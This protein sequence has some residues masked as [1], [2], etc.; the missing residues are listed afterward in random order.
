MLHD[1]HKKKYHEHIRIQ[2][3]NHPVMKGPSEELVDQVQTSKSQ[4]QRLLMNHGMSYPE[5]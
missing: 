1:V 2:E 3:G 5:E 4:L